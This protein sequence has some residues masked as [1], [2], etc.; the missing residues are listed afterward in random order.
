H[1]NDVSFVFHVFID[2]IPEADIQRLAQLA[3]SYRTCIQIHLVNCERLKALPTTKNWSIAMYFRFV[4]ADYFI[5]QQDK[6]LYLD[7]DIACQGNLKPLITMDLANNVAAVVTE[8]DANWW[9]LRGQS[10]QCNE[11][12]KG[13]FNSG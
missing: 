5:D 12:E 4:I 9:S 6:I 1:N 11:L 13:Y 8:R 7:A 2:D 10:L 3:K